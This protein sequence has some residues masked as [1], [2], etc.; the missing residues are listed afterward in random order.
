LC[1]LTFFLFPG[2]WFSRDWLAIK[3]ETRRADFIPDGHFSFL[4]IILVA[5][6]TNTRIIKWDLKINNR[7]DRS[8]HNIML[9]YY[10]FIT[11]NN[12]TWYT[13]SVFQQTTQRTQCNTMN[14]Y[15][16]VYIR[17]PTR[18]KWY[19]LSSVS[20][21]ENPPPIILIHTCISHSPL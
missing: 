18:M 14:H 13:M 16:L 1:Y 12:H 10:M 20:L 6:S 4:S 19:T 9:L 5:L 15:I 8:K 21:V 2:R 3:C 7:H 17:Q 11:I